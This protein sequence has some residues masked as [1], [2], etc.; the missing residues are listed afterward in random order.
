[1]A[2]SPALTITLDHGH[3]RQYAPGMMEVDRTVDARSPRL[4]LPLVLH[5]RPVIDITREQFFDLC[6]LNPDVQIERTSEGD[7]VI[8]APTGGET[9]ARNARLV[10]QVTRWADEDGSG[11]AFDSSTGFELPNGAIRAPDVAW[12]QR[13]RLSRLSPEEKQRFLPL[14]PDFVI[15]VRSPFDTLAAVR[16]KM[17][18]YRAHGT[19]LGW[20]IDPVRKQVSIYRVDGSVEHLD[21]PSDITGDPIVPGFVVHLATIWESAF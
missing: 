21:Q 20:L 5:V 4:K 16:D 9:G 10:A 13:S 15:E 6:R 18:E 11:V 3:G 14:C 1:M 8:M 7:I 2:R 17:E 12:V 19:A